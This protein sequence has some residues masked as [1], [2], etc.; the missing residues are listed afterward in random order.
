VRPLIAV[1]FVA[2]VAGCGGGGSSQSTGAV[3]GRDVYESVSCGGCHTFGPAGSTG[4]AGP[5]L[6]DSRVSRS[7]ATRIVRDGSGA[8]PGFA[9]QLTD[10]QI[11][12]VVDFVVSGRN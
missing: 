11:R 3:S 5:S 2:L 12:A 6:D 1:A 8:M 9:D 7:R 4:K 10:A